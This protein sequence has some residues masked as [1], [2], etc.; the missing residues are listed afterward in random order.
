MFLNRNTAILFFAQCMFVT[1]TVVMVTLGG[2]VGSEL[3]PL[4]V[5]TTLPMS[6]MVIGTALTT[7]PAS[8][9][10]RRFGRRPGFMSAALAGVCACLLGIVALDA[11]SFPLFCVA[12]G[13]IG[14]SVAF[15]Q[16]FRFAAAESVPTASVPHAVSFIL[17]GSIGGALLGPELAWRSPGWLPEAPYAGAFAAALVCYALAAACLTALRVPPVAKPM[18]GDDEPARPLSRIVTAPALTAAILG[19]VVGQGVMTFIMTATPVSM[20]VVDGHDLAHT[21]SVIRAHV[22]AMYIPSLFSG[23]LIGWVGVRTVM[24]LGIVAFVAT[25][26]LGLQG[27]AYLDY[28]GALVLLGIGW[29]FLFV[30]GTTLLVANYRPSER[31]QTQA[32]NDFSVF[33]TSALAS[34]M[35]GAVLLEFGWENVLLVATV[36]L[37]LVV[38]ALLRLGGR[39]A[40]RVPERV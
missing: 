34:L 27:H 33:G 13:L 24:V 4:A 40:A 28:W 22:L 32:V 10:M 35:G 38:A 23:M 7:V 25:V 6:L 30:G 36:P 1:G 9:S 11:A 12:A 8:M 21:A 20:H 3:A 2:I 19:G 26:V 5:L 31:F 29:N 17:V 18:P 15:S 39:A 16:Q 37:V 14:V